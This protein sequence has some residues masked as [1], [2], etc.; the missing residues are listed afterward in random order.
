M[1]SGPMRRT[2]PGPCRRDRGRPPGRTRWSRIGTGAAAAVAAPRHRMHPGTR[3]LRWWRWS[4]WAGR[5]PADR[6]WAAAPP[7]TE[8]AMRPAR[9]PPPN[10]ATAL[11]AVKTSAT[12]ARRVPRGPYMRPSCRWPREVVG[13]LRLWWCASIRRMKR[14]SQGTTTDRVER[15]GRADVI[16]PQPWGAAVC[17]DSPERGRPVIRSRW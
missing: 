13:T 4:R 14:A 17:I 9:R 1:P 12:R 5:R 7:P 16:D 15:A 6:S 3:C 2:D 10:G 11:D 8:W